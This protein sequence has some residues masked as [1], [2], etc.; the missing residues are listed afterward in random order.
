MSSKSRSTSSIRDKWK[1][2]KWYN[3]I[4]PKLF[5]EVSLGST[6]AFD[7]TSTI[8]RKI[9]TTLYD[10]T[11]D[12]S[13]VYVH[14]YFKINKNDSDKLFTMFYGHELSRDYVRSLVRR[15]SSKINSIVEVTTKDGYKL[16][17]K[18]L[19]LTTYRIHR[20]QRSAIRKIMGDMIRKSA[21]S[22]TFDEFIQEMIFGKLASD[23]FNEAKKIAPLRKV[24]VEKSKVTFVPSMEVK[25]TVEVSN[26]SSG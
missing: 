22:H 5:G 3:I 8:G 1:L 19:A 25:N 12:F 13:L 9:E 26:S 21:E 15:K 18:G 23:M 2:K 24:E 7:A 20:D 4:S 10:L 17:V 6:P 11:G 14:L 16:R